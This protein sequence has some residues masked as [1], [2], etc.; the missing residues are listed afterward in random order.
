MVGF[1]SCERFQSYC[2]ALEK[3]CTYR[4]VRL[5]R[6]DNTVIGLDQSAYHVFILDQL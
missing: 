2:L 5:E 1:V 4:I 3:R 6:S